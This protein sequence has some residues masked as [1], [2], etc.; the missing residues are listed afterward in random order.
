MEMS[1]T[2]AR[3]SREFTVLHWNIQWG[4]GLFRSPGTME[5]QRRRSRRDT[6]PGGHQRGSG[7]LDREARR[8]PG[9]G[10]S[11][12]DILHDSRAPTGIAWRCAPGGRLSLE[13][14]SPLPGGAGMASWPTSVT[15]APAPRG[16]W[17]ELADSSRCPSCRRSRDLQGRRCVGPAL[18]LRRRRLQ[19]AKPQPRLR[20]AEG[21][22]LPPGRP[23]VSGWR[24]TFPAWLPVYDIDHVWI[25]RN[26]ASLP[27][28]SSTV[29]RPTIADKSFVSRRGP[30][31]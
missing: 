30:H 9:S 22:G 17:P 11:H 5:A 10:A 1:A 19:H 20:R 23:F 21:P 6:R 15:A 2:P 3:R 13:E 18:R 14:R 8:R 4:G 26:L 25:G 12:V 7:Q 28:R 24:A 31:P 27:A 29:P 16:R